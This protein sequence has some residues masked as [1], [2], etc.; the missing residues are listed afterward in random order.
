MAGASGSERPGDSPGDDGDLEQPS[1]VKE[2]VRQPNIVR[3][4]AR[5]RPRDDCFDVIVESFKL[6]GNAVPI[7]SVPVAFYPSMAGT[8]RPGSFITDGWT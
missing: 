7:G 1:N 2:R 3:A 8:S 4:I 5:L 6:R